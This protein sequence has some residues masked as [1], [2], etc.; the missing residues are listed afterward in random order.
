MGVVGGVELA[1]IPGLITSGFGSTL[2]SIGLGA[3]IL[4]GIVM[5]LP[6]MILI[7]IMSRIA[8]RRWYKIV[9]EAGEIVD[10]APDKVEEYA[11][12]SSQPTIPQLDP[13]EQYPSA[14][15]SFAPIFIPVVLS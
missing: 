14:L 12:L 15:M 5:G 2:A 4:F 6:V 7:A 10:V 9:D 13:G 8:G 3:Y 1:T 11:R